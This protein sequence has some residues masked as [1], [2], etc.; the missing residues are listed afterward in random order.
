MLKRR[1][2]TSTDPLNSHVLRAGDYL[3]KSTRVCLEHSHYKCMLELFMT[4]CVLWWD[5]YKLCSFFFLFELG[6]F[7][8]SITKNGNTAEF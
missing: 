6:I 8:I 7:P 1:L 3:M 4:V 2:P 5:I